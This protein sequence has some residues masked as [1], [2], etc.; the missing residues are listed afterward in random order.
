MEKCNGFLKGIIVLCVAIVLGTILL[1]AVFGLPTNK[2]VENVKESAKQINILPQGNQFIS[3]MDS[4]YYDSF[5]DSLMMI[6]AMY[7][8]GK[9]SIVNRA[10]NIYYFYYQDKNADGYLG[11]WETLQEYYWNGDTNKEYDVFSYERYWHG[12]LVFLKP[13]LYVMSYSSIRI[14]NIFLQLMFSGFL[15]WLLIKKNQEKFLVPFGITYFILN[16]MTLGMNLQLS[17][18][19]YIMLGVLSTLA[20]KH[21]QI[22]RKN[23]Y[24]YIFLVSGILTSYFDYLTYPLITLGIPLLFVLQLSIGEEWSTIFK[25]E[26][27]CGL[28]WMGGYLGMWGGKVLVG[29]L[30][31]GKNIFWNIL[32]CVKVRTGSINGEET[33]GYMKVLKLNLA[34]L[35]FPVYIMIIALVV[36][37]SLIYSCYTI[38]KVKSNQNGYGYREI[39]SITTALVSYF[40][41]MLIPF[42]WYAVAKNHSYVHSW[43]TYREIAISICAVISCCIMMPSILRKKIN[44]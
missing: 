20:W 14:L 16:P 21:E 13:L 23:L 34:P 42:M 3:G 22:N 40:F 5:T 19:F 17:S 43:M 30:L 41:I 37:L 35:Q 25:R 12:Y 11:A 33:F 29:S 26:L 7:N 39:L 2:I 15:V 28:S 24:S 4:T 9:H 36:L 27:K 44:E 31:T 6:N 38:K 10:M 18:V 1:I 32:S 8:D